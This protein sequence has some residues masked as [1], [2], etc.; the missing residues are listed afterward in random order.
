MFPAGLSR[1]CVNRR[2]TDHEELFV[3]RIN[4][5]RPDYSKV[6]L[7]VLRRLQVLEGPLR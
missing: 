1:V 7:V 2:R 5:L 6:Q 3:S 4:P